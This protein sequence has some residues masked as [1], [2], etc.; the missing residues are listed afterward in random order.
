MG[1]GRRPA[2]CGRSCSGEGTECG[3]SA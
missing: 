1:R 3:A 2:A